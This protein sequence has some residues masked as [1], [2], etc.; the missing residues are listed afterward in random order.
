MLFT[1]GFHPR[2][3]R[4]KLHHLQGS[5]ESSSLLTGNLKMQFLFS[6]HSQGSSSGIPFS[7]KSLGSCLPPPPQWLLVHSGVSHSLTTVLL[8]SHSRPT[9]TE[10]QYLP[11]QPMLL[12]ESSAQ[13]DQKSRTLSHVYSDVC[14]PCSNS[15][16]LTLGSNHLWCV[17]PDSQ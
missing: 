15:Q 17:S 12:L 10:Q 1:V 2:Q 7:S 13:R 4:N 3:S 14:R 6:Q 11:K 8:G 16:E 9:L 5:T